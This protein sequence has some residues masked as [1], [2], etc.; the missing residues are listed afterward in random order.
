MH[1]SYVLAKRQAHIFIASSSSSQTAI[2][3]EAARHLGLQRFK[4]RP[5]ADG[6]RWGTR[7][8]DGS[9]TGLIGDLTGGRSDVG[10]ASSFSVPSN[11]HVVDYTWPHTFIS[12]CFAVS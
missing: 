2:F 10:W 6:R 11:H 8:A 12:I 3:R 1:P 4:I 5:E 7:L 9:F